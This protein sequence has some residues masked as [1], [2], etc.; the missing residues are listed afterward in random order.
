MSKLTYI[1][2]GRTSHR[3]D[4]RKEER[5][6]ER[7]VGSTGR[8]VLVA[9]SGV[10]LVAVTPGLW[11]IFTTYFWVGFPGLWS[12]RERAYRCLQTAAGDSLRTLLRGE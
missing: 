1:L 2:T 8:G 5:N 12:P 11:W 10:F 4:Y 6:H 7:Y 9:I 3:K